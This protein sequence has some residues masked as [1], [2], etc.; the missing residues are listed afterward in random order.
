L[1]T[2]NNLTPLIIIAGMTLFMTLEV[3]IPY[4]KHSAGRT[5]QRRSNVGMIAIG[6]IISAVSAGMFALPQI[7]SEANNF[8]LLHRLLGQSVPAIVIG[9]FCIDLLSYALHVTFHSV[10]MMWRFHRVHHADFE[11]D[12]SSGIRLHP[13]ELI[14][15]LSQQPTILALLGIPVAS[16]VLY[17]ALALPWFLLNHSN[18]KFPAWFESWGSLLMSTPNWHRVHHSSYQPETDSHYGCLFSI[19]D[20]LFGTD[21]KA[22]VETIRF[23]LDRFRDAGEQTVWQLLKMPFMRL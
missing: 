21:R 11:L 20:R 5:R 16:S 10:P 19:W 8:G 13:F 14:I 2:L 12:A 15:L 18:I 17:G 1:E 6:F 4:F 3:W 7:W 9:I 23:G 22:E